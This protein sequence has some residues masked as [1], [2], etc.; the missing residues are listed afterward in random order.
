MKLLRTAAFALIFTVCAVSSS[1]AIVGAGFHWGFDF[2]MDMK[3]NGMDAVYSVKDLPF[4][5]PAEINIDADIPFLYISRENWKRSVINFGGKAYIDIIPVIEAIELSC[6]FGLWQYDGMLNYL[7]IKNYD[8]AN[9][10]YESVP[11]GLDDIDGL[12]YFSLGG[13]PYAKFHLDLS[14]RKK[15]FALPGDVMKFNAGAGA[16][17]HFATPLLSSNLITD[18]LSAGDIESLASGDIS[19]KKLNDLSKAI[20]EKIIDGLAKPAFGMHILL[21]TQFKLP[22]LPLGL[23]V[24]GKFMI[25]FTK[26]EDSDAGEDLKGMGFLINTGISLSF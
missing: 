17:A 6:N 18:V 26:F 21:G 23:Y 5:L 11:L 4:S 9:P 3:D 10:K 24:D 20:I 19:E 25:P 15:L 22:V 14:I 1:Y 2:S 16:S 12:K 13:T 8:P 7:D